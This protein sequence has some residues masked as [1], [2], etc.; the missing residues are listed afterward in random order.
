MYYLNFHH[1][2]KLTLPVF[3]VVTSVLLA[4]SGQAQDK[5]KPV[6]IQY[7]E[8]GNPTEIYGV[9]DLS[10][11]P[12]DNSSCSETKRRV[13]GFFE[14]FKFIQSITRMFTGSVSPDP[15]MSEQ[16]ETLLDPQYPRTLKEQFVADQIRKS[17]NYFSFAI[18]AGIGMKGGT[19]VYGSLNDKISIWY[20]RIP[21]L[22]V[23]YNIPLQGGNRVFVDVDPYYAIALAG[24]S[25]FGA[26]STTLK[27]G[28]STGS[29]FKRG[30]YGI[31]IMPGIRLKNQPILFGLVADFGLRNLYPDNAFKVHNSSFGVAVGYAL[32]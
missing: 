15:T 27:F 16:E 12:T 7:D 32:P 17:G 8:N 2:S 24:N 4:I 11:Q 9:G 30:D 20:L 29:S 13:D 10:K 1:M 22:K 18:G 3:L 19:N 21:E 14:A 28:S 23:R 5:P 6:E 26:T 31:A 25:K